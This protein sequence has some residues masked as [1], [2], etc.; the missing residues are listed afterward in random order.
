VIRGDEQTVYINRGLAAGIRPGDRLTVWAPGE[1][2]IDPETGFNLGSDEQFVC[3]VEVRR[4]NDNFS[5]ATPGQTCH[6]RIINRGDIVRL[7]GERQ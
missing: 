6:G 4:V 3:S 2:L 7:E 5:V 1:A